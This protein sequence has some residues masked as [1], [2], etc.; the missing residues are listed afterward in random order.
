M[1]S[2]FSDFESNRY[3]GGTR[4]FLESNS[5]VAK[6]AFLLLVLFIFLFLLRIG[7]TLVTWLF[8]P[9]QTPYLVSGLKQANTMVR[10][11]QDPSTSGA[12]PILRSV[13]EEEGIEFTWST[14]IYV[15]DLEPRGQLKHVFHKGSEAGNTAPEG[16][17]K[18]MLYPNNAPGLYIDSNTNSL[19]IVMNTFNSIIEEIKVDDLPLNKW[20]SV[21]IVCDNL[22]IDV[23]ING[24]IARR[25]ILKSVPRQNYGDVWVNMN[26]GFN[27]YLSDLQYYN[28]S[29]GVSKIQS[30]VNSG[31]NL[32]ASTSSGISA[33]NPPYLS[34][35][36]YLMGSK[37]GYNM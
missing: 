9:S 34:M 29:L 37:D 28:Y 25:H 17:E 12:I 13:N 21:M 8:S 26:G 4:D 14:W 6:V 33:N 15:E 19:V 11:P 5:L 32:K 3:V 18:G 7:V 30:I 31:P 2:S 27:G 23:Y 35:R 10:I 20:V 1:S 22:T 24:T 16:V 36:W